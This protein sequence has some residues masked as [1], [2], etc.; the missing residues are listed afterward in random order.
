M[1]RLFGFAMIVIGMWIGLTIY[2][3]GIEGVTGRVESLVSTSS[4]ASEGG[5]KAEQEGA[6]RRSLPQRVGDVVDSEMEKRAQLVSKR[7]DGL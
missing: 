2:T 5:A 7:M 6:E 3:E 1:G 4:D